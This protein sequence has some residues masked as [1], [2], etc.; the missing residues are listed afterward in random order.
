MESCAPAAGVACVSSA[1]QV[2]ARS[3]ARPA[4][5]LGMPLVPVL[6]TLVAGPPLEQP[7]SGSKT[8]RP[9]G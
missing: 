4:A 8:G 3:G 9:M 6:N 7:G 1:L 5:V 2:I